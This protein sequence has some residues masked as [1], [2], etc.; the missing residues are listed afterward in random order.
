[1]KPLLACLA[2]FCALS[3]PPA[4]AQ[5]SATENKGLT[6][7]EVD[8]Q[9][10][11]AAKVVGLPG[12][13]RHVIIAHGPIAELVWPAMNWHELAVADPAMLR[14]IKVG[15][16]VRFN[17]NNYGVITSIARAPVPQPQP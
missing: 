6:P 3:L 13:G 15:D 14:G 2:L 11:L 7:G 10:Q 4:L 17:V 12:D 8:N 1:M 9:A 5:E 16:R